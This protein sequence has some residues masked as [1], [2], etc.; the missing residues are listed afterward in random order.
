MQSFFNIEADAFSK[1]RESEGKIFLTPY[2]IGNNKVWF[3]S[4]SMND[5]NWV[6]KCSEYLVNLL[7]SNIS[8]HILHT[9]RFTFPL[10][11]IRRICF[12]IKAAK[13][14]DHFLYSHDL[15]EWFSS[16]TVRRNKMLITLTVLRMT[17]R[18]LNTGA[19]VNFT[20]KFQATGLLII[21]INKFNLSVLV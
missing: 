9:V 1:K 6:H 4:W 21:S 15:N 14:C 16:V 8:I 2:G 3:R 5:C 19:S 11:R 20:I 13:V 17:I 18:F 10:V 7:N 12:T